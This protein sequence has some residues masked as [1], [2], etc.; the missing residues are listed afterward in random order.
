M[1]EY[2]VNFVEL[3]NGERLAYRCAGH[4]E[5]KLLLVHGNL[6]SSVHWQRVI[7]QFEPYFTI[8]APDM[9]GYGESSYNKSF[10][11][12]RELA[13]DIEAFVNLLEIDSFSVVGWSTGGAVALEL[14]ANLGER[15]EKLVLLDAV[16]P[17]GFPMFKK[18][19]N[20]MAIHSQLLETKEEIAADPV[21]II[22]VLE[23]FKSGNRDVLRRIWDSAMYNLN[24]P[25]QEEY[26]RFIDGM[27][28]QRNL[29]DAY[30]ALLTIN[31]TSRVGRSAVGSGRLER[32]KC[33]IVM[34]HGEKDLVIPFSWAQATVELIGEKAK[35]I[36]FPNCGHS[37]HTDEP[38]TVLAALKENLL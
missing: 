37:P 16:P 6:S 2:P 1:K 24:Q 30:Y 14:A 33:P 13:E 19:E 27:M 11:S 38:E 28:Q 35:L 17:T 21:Q 36:S 4:A 10:D 23:A 26:E 22:P 32:V 34:L 25:P 7:E 20:G 15:I 12:L 18:D 31:M 8:Y 5:R 9:R 29:V 3:P